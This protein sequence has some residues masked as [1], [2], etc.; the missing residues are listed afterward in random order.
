MLNSEQKIA[1]LDYIIELTEGRSQLLPERYELLK[2]NQNLAQKID[3]LEK[4]LSGITLDNNIKNN[5]GNRFEN[6]YKPGEMV[7]NVTNLGLFR[8]IFVKC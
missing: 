5:T 6:S 3:M 8:K 7:V 1:V 2:E 4:Q